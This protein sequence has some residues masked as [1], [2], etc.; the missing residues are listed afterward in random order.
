MDKI[1]S[2][3]ILT[4]LLIILCGS[5]SIYVLYRI[6]SIHKISAQT[7]QLVIQTNDIH[8]K[9]LEN[10]IAILSF[11][12]T[13]DSSFLDSI[14]V[15]KSAILKKIDTLRS[16]TQSMDQNQVLIDSLQASISERHQVFESALSQNPGP[17]QFLNY[18][19]KHRKENFLK[20]GQKIKAQNNS[21]LLKQQESLQQREQGLINNL[22]V[23]SIIIF[24]VA[25]IAVA[26]VFLS[27]NAFS[28]YKRQ[29]EKANAQLAE[30]KELLEEQ[31]NQ[32]NL[33]NKELEQFAYVASHDLQEPLRKITSFNDLLQEQ[34][35][36]QLEGEGK[37]YLERIAF[38][39]N[40]MRKLIT[41]L[42][43]YSRAGRHKEEEEILDLKTVAEEVMDDLYILIMEKNAKINIESLPNLLGTYLDWRTIFQNLLSNAIKFAKPG[44]DPVIN[45]QTEIASEKLIHEHVSEPDPE[46]EYYHIQVSDNGIGFNPEYAERIFII[47]QRLYG[48]DVYEGTGIGLAVC[49]K[50]LD[51]LG[52]S[53][54][55]VS[56]EGEGATFHLLVPDY[57]K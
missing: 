9:V 10:E 47:F 50:I 55:A 31:V 57:K 25:L 8:T 35:K 12:T 53:I 24:A 26:A 19:Q 54:F 33:S 29:Q 6:K 21:I 7:E 15:R 34:Y 46:V 11:A 13:Y 17:E 43:E 42:L 52:G 22:N 14:H 32:L 1:K 36:D 20:F 2:F 45:I 41:D 30:Y 4:L 27:F 23:L 38:A 40:R 49:K 56:Q 51:K 44:I 3:T 28:G 39:A 37:L 18:V 5:I 48:K 16:I